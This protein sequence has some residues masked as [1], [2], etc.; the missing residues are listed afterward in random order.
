[1]NFQSNFSAPFIKRPVATSLVTIAI[2]LA[3]AIAFRFLPVA[4]LPASGPS[5]HRCRRGPAGRQPG[6]HGL[7][8]SNS[9][10]APVRAY[11]GRNA[12]DLVLHSRQHWHH[13]SVRSQS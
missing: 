3:G 4:P 6:N 11:C 2:L 12:N 5:Y 7:G 8:S 1:M 13:S 10:G 9:T